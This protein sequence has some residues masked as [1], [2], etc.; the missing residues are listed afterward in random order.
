MRQSRGVYQT[1]DAGV[2]LRRTCSSLAS[3]SEEAHE[4]IATSSLILF[5]IRS[6][7][8]ARLKGIIS[9]ALC[10][11]R[12]VSLHGDGAGG[13]SSQ[14]WLLLPRSRCSKDLAIDMES[15]CAAC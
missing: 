2:S 10:A 13:V 14:A 1:Y 9:D 8:Y 5:L 12:Q 3:P 7:R 11:M 15:F 6:W 4:A